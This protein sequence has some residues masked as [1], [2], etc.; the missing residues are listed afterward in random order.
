MEVLKKAIYIRVKTGK[1]EGARGYIKRIVNG[2]RS[3]NECIIYINGIEADPKKVYLK[4]SEI[5]RL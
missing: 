1:Y 4:D 5:E 2:S 3:P